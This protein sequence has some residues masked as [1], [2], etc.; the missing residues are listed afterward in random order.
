MS[1]KNSD[2]MRE[3]WKDAEYRERQTNANQ[4]AVKVPRVLSKRRG[5]RKMTDPRI[6]ELE[7]Q[8]EEATDA[9]NHYED[10]VA[11][12]V[13]AFDCPNPAAVVE[14]VQA[15]FEELTK[16]R[17]HLREKERTTRQQ[18]I[19]LIEEAQALMRPQ[20]EWEAEL[21][22]KEAEIVTLWHALADLENWV[23]MAERAGVTFPRPASYGAWRR[24]DKREG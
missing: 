1:G 6:A 20:G 4:A 13:L 18:A 14:H 17:D 12:F 11:R 3:R 15:L 24:P 19:T 9:A 8:L 10:T 21:G 5:K 7:R 22:E 23:V 2:A 16:E